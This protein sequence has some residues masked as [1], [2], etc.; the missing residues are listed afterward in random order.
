MR[1]LFIVL[2]IPFPCL[3]Q[4]YGGPL[5]ERLGSPPRNISGI[6]YF[7]CVLDWSAP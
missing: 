3:A 1:V 5:G 7:A 6:C 2:A 4:D